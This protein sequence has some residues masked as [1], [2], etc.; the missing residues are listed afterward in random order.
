MA[1]QRRQRSR[2][3]ELFPRSKRPV[4]A[5]QENHRLVQMTDEIDWTELEALVE[6]IRRSKLESDAGRPPHLRALTGA[7]AFRATRKMT[8]RETEDQIRHY[9]PARVDAGCEHD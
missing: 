1:A 9:A 4:I 8:Y 7:L 5:I 3:A 2:Q 6:S